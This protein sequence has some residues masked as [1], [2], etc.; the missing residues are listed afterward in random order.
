MSRSA[1]MLAAVLGLQVV[2]LGLY[3]WVED[4]RS[5]PRDAPTLGRAAP[6]RVHGLAPPLSFTARDGGRVGVRS[7]ERPTLLHFWATWCPP[8]LA[9]LPALLALPERVPVD[10]ITVALDQDWADVDRFFEGQTPPSALLG[11]AAEIEASLD[12][13]NLPV[14]I[15]ILPGGQFH[16][17][18]EGSRDWSDAGFVEAWLADLPQ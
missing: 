16:L 11:D 9:E 14:T 7:V 13:R 6:H 10:I 4:S 12:I 17:R 3:W 2:L 18:F 15:L 8:C 5:G 1:R